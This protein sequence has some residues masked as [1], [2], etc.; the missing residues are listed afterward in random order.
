[1]VRYV[2]DTVSV[3]RAGRVVETGATEQVLSAPEDAYTRE[4][5]AAVPVM[6]Q[7][8]YDRA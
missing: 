8:L 6:G 5:L 1:M 2:S 3:M 4:L 7:P